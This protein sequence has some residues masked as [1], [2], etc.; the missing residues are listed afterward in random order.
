MDVHMI[1]NCSGHFYAV[2]VR[3]AWSCYSPVYVWSALYCVA[4]CFLSLA[5]LNSGQFSTSDVAVS[6]IAGKNAS[7]RQEDLQYCTFP[8]RVGPDRIAPELVV[9]MPLFILA[10]SDLADQSAELFVRAEVSNDPARRL[11]F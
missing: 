11:K 7:I 4:L 9:V 8:L 10:L 2:P 5:C 3:A 1:T 6:L